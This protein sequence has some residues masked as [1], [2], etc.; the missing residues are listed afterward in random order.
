MLG[1]P[2]YRLHVFTSRGRHLLQR[3]GRLRTPLGYAGAFLTNARQP[4]GAWAAGWS[5]WS[6]PTRAI[7]CH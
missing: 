4:Q 1:H 7:R 3:E 6:S 5:G 2:R